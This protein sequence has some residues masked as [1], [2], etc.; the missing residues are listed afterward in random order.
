ML[1]RSGHADEWPKLMERLCLS[2]LMAADRLLIFVISTLL[3]YSFFY[4]LIF[5]L[6]RA[7]E[8]HVR[9]DTWEFEHW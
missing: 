2:D 3:S 8:S 1:A 7:L 9:P 4:L 5:S 6:L